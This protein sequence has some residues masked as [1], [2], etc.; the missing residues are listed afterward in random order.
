MKQKEEQD[1]KLMGIRT[2]QTKLLKQQMSAQSAIDAQHAQL[3]EINSKIIQAKED[4]EKANN[5][6]S[7]LDLTTTNLQ[8]Q[9]DNETKA[10]DE[11]EKT[12]VELKEA[13]SNAE[14]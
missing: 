10:I 1:E 7:K 13:L 8:K 4:Q 5:E 11:L 12:K 6:K 2:L 3:E 14:Q 9:K